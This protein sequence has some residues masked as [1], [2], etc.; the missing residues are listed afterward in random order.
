[1]QP[2]VGI[3]GTNVEGPVVLMATQPIVQPYVLQGTSHDAEEAKN[4]LEFL[5]ERLRVI[6]GGGSFG[7]GTLQVYV[8]CL[9]L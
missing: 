2:N 8:W 1:M 3:T 7:F 9:I 6:K 4:K 5:E